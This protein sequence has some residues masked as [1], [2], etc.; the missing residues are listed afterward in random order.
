[1][2]ICG[3][4]LYAV[5]NWQHSIAPV[6][7]L[8]PQHAKLHTYSIVTHTPHTHNISRSTVKAQITH[9]FT[10]SQI[11]G[12]T[13]VCLD[14]SAIKWDIMFVPMKASM[15]AEWLLFDFDWPAPR[16]VI[17]WKLWTL[18]WHDC[19]NSGWVLFA[20]YIHTALV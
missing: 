5:D 10:Q 20:I 3:R 9:K 6:S 2:L 18:W 19:P 16:R 15:C 8:Y 4:Y 14:S 13:L 7:H 17:K 11:S 1:M 12:V